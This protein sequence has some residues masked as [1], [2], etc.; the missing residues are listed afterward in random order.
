[1]A[2]PVYDVVVY[3][4][5]SAGVIA[6]VQTARMGKS[7]VLVAPETHLGGLTINGLG[8]TD[9]GDASQIGGLS[10][11]FYQRVKQH[12]DDSS[13]WVYEEPADLNA[14]R[15]VGRYNPESDAIWV[16]EP[17]VAEDIYVEM[18]DDAGVTIERDAWLD[19]ENGV[20][21]A[22][23]RIRSIKTLDGEIYR[24]HMF[25][26][27]T[28][29]GDLM[30]AAGVSYT[31]G[32]ES[33][34]TYNENWNGVQ[35]TARHHQHFFYNAVDPF[36]EPGNPQSGVLPRVQPGH[37]GDDGEG[38]H[39]VQ[40]YCFRMCMTDVEDNLV[41]WPKPPNYDPLQYELLL[42]N[43]ETGDHRLPLKIDMMPNRKTDTNNRGAF[44][45]DNIGMNYDYP[46]AS[47][48]ERREIYEEHLHYQ[49]GLM[50]TMAN[51][52]RIPKEIRD[53][54]SSWGLAA[55]EFED[56]N[57]WPYKL[58]IRE[59]RRMIGE[60][61]M[62]EHDCRRTVDT[63]YSVGLG[64]YTM[65]SHN[66]QRYITS[67]GAVQNEGDIGIHPG[68]PY[69][70]AYHSLTPKGEECENLLVP[71]CL[72]SSHIAYGSI[73]MEPVFMILGQSAATAAVHAIEE[74]QSVQHIDLD[75]LQER[76]RADGQILE[77]DAPPKWPPVNVHSLAGVV[78]DDQYAQREGEWLQSTSIAPYVGQGY[79]HDDNANKG[80]KT[81]RFEAAVP[82]GRY[83][84]RF[85]YTPSG[86][87]AS[88]V[89]IRVHHAD[90]TAELEIDQR[91]TPLRIQ[92]ARYTSLGVFA[93]SGDESA[94]V[95]IGNADT[96]GHVVAD[97]MQWIAQ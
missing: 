57:H 35:K 79:L 15:N 42:R 97:A 6:A 58:Y 72:S 49:Q 74:E 25:I 24:G 48:E 75:R 62:T 14:H 89:P 77:T 51:H 32:R 29:V 81:L 61:V 39:R 13:A 7:V 38:D 45:T 16:F 21:M 95:E 43:F 4:G 20:E 19:R 65:D 46:E 90:G 69:E 31:V 44:S 84:V 1:M 56:N 91:D 41:P 83:E 76:L 68:G 12:Y 36:I 33:N 59:A 94:V 34:E 73:R 30:A 70:I 37:P 67:D 96:D 17:S 2:Q 78:V 8:W 47:Y 80:D 60:Y 71:I 27:A 82:E 88:N 93:F 3:G 26:D 55:D 66:T 85:F 18:L 9:T 11:E 52:P 10:R 50:W 63:P 22:E 54:V 64:S 28:Y 86:N 5:S 53:T 40:A 23:G 87:R 92:G